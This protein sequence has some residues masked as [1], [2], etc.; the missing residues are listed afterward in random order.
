M[1]A[2]RQRATVAQNIV[3]QWDNTHP[4]RKNP[5][6]ATRVF[7]YVYLVFWWS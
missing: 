1:R 4:K 7:V 5:S 6:L 2:G 3:Y